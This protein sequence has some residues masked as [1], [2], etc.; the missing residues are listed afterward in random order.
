[1]RPSFAAGSLWN[2]ETSPTRFGYST[3]RSNVSGERSEA[4]AI[5]FWDT[6]ESAEAYSKVAFG[7][8]LDRL[9]S[10][11]AAEPDVSTL[12]VSNWTPQQLAVA[13]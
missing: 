7:P 2:R 6:R 12:V 11:L 10:V 5:S 1:M 4:V 8:L 9:K 3:N 13:S